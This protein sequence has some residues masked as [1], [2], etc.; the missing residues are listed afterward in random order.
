MNNET[1][2]GHPT[3]IANAASIVSPFP[4]P[5][6]SYIVGAN[7]GNPNPAHDRRNE[8]AARAE[9]ACSVKASTT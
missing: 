7:S 5:S 1:P 2:A 8:T 4:Y 6:A 3:P 9:A